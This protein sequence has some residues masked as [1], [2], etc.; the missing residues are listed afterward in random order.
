MPE[1]WRVTLRD[2][3]NKLIS[4]SAPD[5][6]L[7][8]KWKKASNPDGVP[9]WSNNGLVCTVETYKSYVKVTFAKG[10]SLDDPRALFNASLDGNA[11]RAIDI[12]EGGKL[13]T[14]GFKDLIAQAVALNRSLG[15]AKKH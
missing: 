3:I 4:Q 10:A 7:E 9:T 1:D 13:D 6:V 11:R 2:K 8:Y 5:M 12:L 15:Q 14:A